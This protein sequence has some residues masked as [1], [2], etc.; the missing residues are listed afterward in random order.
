MLSQIFTPRYNRPAI[1]LCV[2]YCKSTF[3]AVTLN[4]CSSKAGC[5]HYFNMAAGTFWCYT[6]RKKGGPYI[7]EEGYVIKLQVIIVWGGYEGLTSTLDRLF[8]GASSPLCWFNNKEF[9]CS[10]V[11]VIHINPL[12]L[13]RLWFNFGTDKITV[14]I[15]QL[16]CRQMSDLAAKDSK[17][18]NQD[19]TECTI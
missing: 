10:T 3:L 4:V 13:D 18:G 2:T 5:S 16:I 12:L 19:A 9:L 8:W 6:L 14:L 17:G 1:Q 7:P 11:C 15:A